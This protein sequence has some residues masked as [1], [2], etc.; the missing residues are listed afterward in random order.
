[1]VEAAGMVAAAGTAARSLVALA[2]RTAAVEWV[3]VAT[4]TAAAAEAVRAAE[5]VAEVDVVE[6]V[7]ALA[8]EETVAVGMGWVLWAAEA[9]V[10]V[11]WGEVA[12]E[13][14]ESEVAASVAV[15]EVVAV[16]VMAE[17]GAEGQKGVEA[18][19]AGHWWAVVV[20]AR[21]TAGQ[22]GEAMATVEQVE[23]TTA[24]AR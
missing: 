5:R 6:A 18:G 21:A 12:L 13:V 17:L 22:A 19:I 23:V 8:V 1:M 14:V 20:V 3:A 4:A 7:T 16:M 10:G 9:M 2:A 15:E 11:G 24:V